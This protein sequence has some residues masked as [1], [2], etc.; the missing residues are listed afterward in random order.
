MVE[1]GV[2]DKGESFW[3]RRQHL[4]RPCSKRDH[5]VVKELKEGESA[6]SAWGLWHESGLERQAELNYAKRKIWARNGK[7]LKQRWIEKV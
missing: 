7:A 3:K 6:Q 1:V 2:L 4:G 5:N